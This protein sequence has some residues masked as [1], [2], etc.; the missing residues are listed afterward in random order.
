LLVALAALGVL[1]ATVPAMADE[2]TEAR[3]HFRKGMSMI[4]DGQYDEGIAE[5]KLAYDTLPHPNVLYNIARAYVEMGD[6]DNAIKHYKDYAATNPPD[7]EEVAAVISALEQRLARQRA[8]LAAAETATATPTPGGP[9]APGPA[10]RNPHPRNAN[11]RNAHP[12]NAHP[13]CRRRGA[14]RRVATRST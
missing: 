10:P 7:R 2:R 13:S 1:C 8:T 4:S 5:L 12:R 14:S 11:P 6:L 9:P 3:A